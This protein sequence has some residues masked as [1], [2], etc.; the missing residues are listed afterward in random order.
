MKERNEVIGQ[1]VG[2]VPECLFVNQKL[3][4]SITKTGKT[5]MMGLIE[6]SGFI[7]PIDFSKYPRYNDLSEKLQIA[8]TADGKN[9]LDNIYAWLSGE[10]MYTII[11]PLVINKTAD[12]KIIKDWTTS[13]YTINL[14]KKELGLNDGEIN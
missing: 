7:P 5:L 11:L 6:T 13:E 10:Q 2:S 14:L 8:L 1:R 3:S 4:D 12:E 9:P